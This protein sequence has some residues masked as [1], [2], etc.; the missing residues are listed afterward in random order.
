MSVY[1][2]N[3]ALFFGEVKFKEWP[4]TLPP[5]PQSAVFIRDLFVLIHVFLC[6]VLLM[7]SEIQATP[8]WFV[9]VFFWRG[10]GGTKA[11]V[12]MLAGLTYILCQS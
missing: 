8:F 2:W 6:S 11:V 5:P 4:S 10:S 12:T 9:W 7:L 1:I 3:K